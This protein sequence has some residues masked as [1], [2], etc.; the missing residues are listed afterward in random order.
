MNYKES[1]DDIE[2]GAEEEGSDEET[3]KPI[4]KR[5]YKKRPKKNDKN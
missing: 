5:K 1:Q 3:V 2:A 4:K